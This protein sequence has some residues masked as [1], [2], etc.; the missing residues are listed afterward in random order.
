MPMGKASDRGWYGNG[1]LWTHLPWPTQF[2]RMPS[3]ML[4]TKV[5]W[6]RARNGAVTLDA[7]PLHGPSARFAADVGSPAS[8]GPTGFPPPDPT[9]GSRSLRPDRARIFP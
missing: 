6:F 5:P 3:G 2:S 9:G 1:V 4:Y 7:E 8:Y